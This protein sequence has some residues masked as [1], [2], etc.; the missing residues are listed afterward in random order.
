MNS[1][2][3]ESSFSCSSSEGGKSSSSSSSFPYYFFPYSP[4]SPFSS[5]LDS[6]STFFSFFLKP[7]GPFYN[8]NMTY[9]FDKLNKLSRP[10]VLEWDFLN[11]HF[12]CK[13]L[14]RW[15]LF[16]ILIVSLES[17]GCCFFVP[18]GCFFQLWGK[19]LHS[20]FYL[21]LSRLNKEAAVR[22]KVLNDLGVRIEE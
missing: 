18:M 21:I 3:S 11:I 9:S 17:S 14:F 10:L 13:K 5:G 16:L 15:A 19:I 2:S 22:E 8:K 7:R 20:F 12:S 1:P 4:F 6:S